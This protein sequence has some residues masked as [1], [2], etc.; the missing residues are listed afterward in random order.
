MVEPIAWWDDPALITS[1]DAAQRVAG[2][3]GRAAGAILRG[4]GAVVIGRDLDQAVARAWALEDRCRVALAAGAGGR[5]FTEAELEAR[6]TWFEAE[7]RRVAAWL[8]GAEGV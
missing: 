5:P 3:L 4:N 6:A 8:L 7:E 1:E 2:A